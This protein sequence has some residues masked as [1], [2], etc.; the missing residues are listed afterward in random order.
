[1]S[2]Q[3]DLY[4]LI[5]QKDLAVIMAD[6]AANNT[7]LKQIL[8]LLKLDSI[9]D[10]MFIRI[11]DNSCFY[12][13]GTP[14]SEY[15]REY[16]NTG[17]WINETIYD[18]YEITNFKVVDYSHPDYQASNNLLKLISGKI[19]IF[20]NRRHQF[21]KDMFCFDINKTHYNSMDLNS[22][23]KL[24]E[25]LNAIANLCYTSIQF[26]TLIQ[27]PK[28]FSK[29]ED[30]ILKQANKE[31]L[32]HFNLSETNIAYLRHIASGCTAKE[33]ATH[34]NKSYRSVQDV[35]QK[36]CDKFNLPSKS[37]LEQVAKIIFSYFK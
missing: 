35:I 12:Y 34:M 9:T 33:I 2:H 15:I 17:N 30:P 18:P 8:N 13:V 32:A 20:L 19:S 28:S 10:F 24:N 11:T 5:S 36:L 37:Q 23:V 4:K 1:M 21:Y 26:L 31:I 29:N 16:H 22:I 27:F 3:L 7:Q 14:S 6:S 25:R